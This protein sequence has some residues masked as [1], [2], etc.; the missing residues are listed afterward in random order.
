MLESEIR[1]RIMSTKADVETIVDALEVKQ[2]KSVEEKAFLL[3][4]QTFLMIDTGILDQGLV[5]Y[6]ATIE[7]KCLLRGLIDY[8]QHHDTLFSS[9]PPGSFDRHIEL[10]RE[11]LLL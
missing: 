1:E 3:I 4:F 10:F 8:Y 9:S 6:L 5:E 7:C 2:E 11:M